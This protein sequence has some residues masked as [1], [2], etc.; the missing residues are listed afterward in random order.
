MPIVAYDE[1]LAD[2]IRDLVADEEGLT[3]QRMF[4]G[5]AFLVNGNMSVAASGQ[6]GVLVR[7]DPD[8]A[9]AWVDGEHWRGGCPIMVAAIELDDQP[10]PLRE[11]LKEKLTGWASLVRR[12]LSFLAEPPLDQES[13]EQAYFELKSI[14]FGYHQSQRLLNDDR[15]RGQ[16]QK[17]Y[18]ALVE[19]WSRRAAA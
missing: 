13:A 3:E 2:R 9:E 19:R 11:Y 7:V 1:E 4:G 16:A 8:E 17:A 5:L 10:G 6:G 18:E 14:F 15:S 12:E